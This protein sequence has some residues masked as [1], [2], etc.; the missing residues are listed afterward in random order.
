MSTQHHIIPVKTYLVIYGI[1]MGLL[2]LTVAAALVDLGPFQFPVS[3]AIAAL[4][5]VLIVLFFMHVRYQDK[6]T[7][8]FSGASFLWLLILLIF[9]LNDYLTR[10][11][12][13]IDGK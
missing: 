3:M 6:L 7:W 2:A 8:V 10:G 13:N 9:T 5:G 1:L 4:K 12:L 11:W